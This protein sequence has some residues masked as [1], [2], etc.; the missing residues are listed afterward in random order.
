[1]N[2]IKKLDGNNITLTREVF[3]LFKR[4]FDEVEIH[5]SHLPDVPYINALLD[6][7]GFHDFAAIFNDKVIGG[8]TA[9]EL[10]M[11]LK[12]RNVFI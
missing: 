12:K 1:M 10:N 7:N 2:N 4:I 3:I 8:L 9:Y 11:Y 5:L 6:K